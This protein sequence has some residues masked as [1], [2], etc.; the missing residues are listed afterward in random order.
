V[1][2][3]Q[4]T[5]V[6]FSALARCTGCAGNAAFGDDA[7]SMN[8]TGVLNVGIGDGVL[9]QNTSGS[10]NTVIGEGALSQI[11]TGS[12]NTVIGA[13]AGS[14]LSGSE[15][16]NIYLGSYGNSG[17]SNTI[18]IGATYSNP[19]GQNAT[20]I[21]GIDGTTISGSTA[22][23]INSSGQLG[24]ISSSRRYKQEVE[25]IGAESSILMSLRPVRFRYR[26]QYDPTGELQY[27]L[28]AEEVEEIAPQLV[29]HD[30]AGRPETVRYHLI[31][32]LLLNEVQRQEHVIAEQTGEIRKLNELLLEQRAEQ[33]RQEA[34]HRE[35]SDAIL[36][37]LS[38]LEAQSRSQ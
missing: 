16:Y 13:G 10:Y 27:G 26:P 17:E 20:Y 33:A 6:G 30:S 35:Q 11:S 28:I 1:G 8:A 37:R 9:A 24:T 19:V 4:N 15:S 36:A 31:N 21:A 22:V 32:T 3:T 14:M 38:A 12:S 25:D 23:Y 7:L 29:I 5:A 18:R 34:R 2:G